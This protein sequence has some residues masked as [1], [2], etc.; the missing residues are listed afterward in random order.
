MFFFETPAQNPDAQFSIE[1]GF[2]LRVCKEA[3]QYPEEEVY[4]LIDEINRGNVPKVL[5]DL[6]STM[7]DSKRIPSTKAEYQGDVIDVWAD[8]DN[9]TITLPYSKR[10]F[11]VPENIKIIITSTTDRSVVP[12]D[13]PFVDDF[14]FSDL[15]QISPMVWELENLPRR[16]LMNQQD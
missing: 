8:Q 6:L 12:L 13:K 15:N 3:L 4:I 1:D 5:G 14:R 2:F 11:F 9:L 7:E 16:G 10:V